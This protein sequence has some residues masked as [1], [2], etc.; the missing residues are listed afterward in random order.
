MGKA[1]GFKEQARQ[2]PEHRDV[3]ER[4]QDWREIYTSWDDQSAGKQAGR[5]MDCGVAFCTNG[6]PLG[7]LIPDW[8]DLVY[9]NNWQ[10]ALK[11]LHTTN[12]FP[13]FTGRICPAPCESSCTLA[14]ND[15]PV[16]IEMIEK[17]IADHGWSRQWIVPQS[18]QQETDKKVAVIGSGP[19]GLAAAQQLRRTGH[20]VTV[21]EKDEYLGGLL[22]LGIPEFKLN[23]SV[24]DRR[25]Q[26]LEQEGVVFKT[27]VTVGHD[28]AADEIL[29]KFDAVCLAIGATV[30]RDLPIT[31]HNLNGIHFAMDYLCQQNRIIKGQQFLE[32]EV[33]SA[34]GKKVVI[35]GGG[36]T[37][38]DCL[39]TAHRQ[40]AASVLQIEILPKPPTTRQKDNPWPQWPL[41]LRTSSA[42]E[43][44]GVRDYSLITKRF[45]SNKQG[46]VRA[47][48]CSRV[49]W[50]KGAN[51]SPSFTEIEDSTF[52]I[53]ADLVLLAMGFLHPD[54]QLPDALGLQYNRR[55][56]VKTDQ[57]LRSS[58]NKVFACGDAQRGQSLVVHAIA[59]GRKCAREIDIFLSGYSELPAV[60]GYARLYPLDGE[61]HM[62]YSTPY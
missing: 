21:F 9:R 17:A 29:A 22:Q 19:A 32:L 58:V 23:K 30:P 62:S 14:I 33:I 57:R 7:N 56:N 5:C 43:E 42:H 2:L 46:A 11:L 20:S 49:T 55:G 44:G 16:T 35:I 10:E 52:I 47:L 1:T 50:G 60:H 40:G 13:E 25:V 18:P 6:C 31:G 27:S 39:G 59:S 61:R 36:D 37:G 28:V 12:N 48:E 24:V 45:L 54:H 15:S 51:Q 38:A 3:A 41:I 34:K 4:L 8:N 26:Q 53:E